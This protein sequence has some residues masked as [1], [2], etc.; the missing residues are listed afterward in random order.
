MLVRTALCGAVSTVQPVNHELYL[1]CSIHPKFS[2]QVSD[3]PL[4]QVCQVMESRSSERRINGEG[5]GARCGIIRP[6]A[7]SGLPEKW[8]DEVSF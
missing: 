1:F 4:Q 3:D 6:V 7:G 5:A 2:T 8:V